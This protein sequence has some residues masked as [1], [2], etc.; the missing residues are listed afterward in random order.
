[1]YVTTSDVDVAPEID[2]DHVASVPFGFCTMYWAVV[3][4]VPFTPDAVVDTVEDML[5]GLTSLTCSFAVILPP[6]SSQPLR[7]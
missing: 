7:A 4:V 6:H 3:I 1:V 2:P 5:A